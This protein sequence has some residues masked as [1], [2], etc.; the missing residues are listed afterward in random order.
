MRTRGR[1]KRG[2]GFNPPR[3]LNKGTNLA[4]HRLPRLF[5]TVRRVCA[6]FVPAF[7]MAS[8]VLVAGC[9][10][11]SGGGL[12]PTPTPT[13]TANPSPF[14]FPAFVTRLEATVAAI[15]KGDLSKPPPKGQTVFYGSSSIEGW[16]TLATDFPNIT[17]VNRGISNSTMPE[18]AYFADRL[19]TPLEPKTAVI[20]EGDNDPYSGLTPQD[21]LAAFKELV[22]RI[23]AKTPGTRFLILSVKPSPARQDKFGD[24]RETNR[25]LRNWAQSDG[26]AAFID[27][28]N[29][30]LNTNGKPRPELFVAD[31]VHLTAEGYKIWT[32]ALQP[33]LGN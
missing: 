31:G 3:S 24:Y 32:V 25:L 30:F 8:V 11:G 10:G 7:L 16:R 17:S 4:F 14:P 5:R 9:G 15:E 33:F 13:P 29:A 26:N 21:V 23:R 22:R 6:A 12:S 20:Y 2:G 18:A 19:V 27:T 1:Y 28:W